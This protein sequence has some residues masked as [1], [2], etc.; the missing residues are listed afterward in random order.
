MTV[1]LSCP[2]EASG[3]WS[4]MAENPWEEYLRFVEN[5]HLIWE[6]RQSGVPGPWTDDPILQAYKFTNVF[7]ILDRG[8]QFL[9]RMMADSDPED[10]L[11]HAF[12]YRYTN[13][14]EPWIWWKENQGSWPTWKDLPVLRYSWVHEYAGPVFGT[15]YTMF[16]GGEN[17]GINRTEW[18]VDL[19]AQAYEFR[20]WR[21]GRN[22][23]RELESL[24]RVGSFMS[25]QIITDK[26]YLD[27]GYDENA[28]VQ[29]GPGSKRGT[30]LLGFRDP[31]EAFRWAQ[32]ELRHVTL[33]G[34]PPSLMDIQNT[35]CEYQK[36]RRYSEGGPRR[37]GYRP[38]PVPE[39]PFIPETW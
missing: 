4:A 9:L 29:A 15:A 38:G 28:W 39:K 21:P 1:R 7:R 13:R 16:S 19:A 11:L 14:P 24:P 17:P 26:G 25:M 33:Y 2:V 10:R 5:R 35:F 18:A 12:L 3:L 31:L 23:A 6:T 37:K 20:W 36:Y 8:T 30:A 34:R 32:G 22:L 27:Q